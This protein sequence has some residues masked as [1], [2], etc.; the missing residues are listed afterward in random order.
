MFSRVQ[1]GWK[2]PPAAPPTS[3]MHAMDL[4]I[5]LNHEGA[6]NTML[7]EIIAFVYL[8]ACRVDLSIYVTRNTDI[9]Q[10]PIS[11]T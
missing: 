1:V 8:K 9:S 7:Q 11:S 5:N 4:N 3:V 10:Q 2:G 6:S